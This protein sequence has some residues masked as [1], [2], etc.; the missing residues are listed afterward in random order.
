MVSVQESV[1]GQGVLELA[2]KHKTESTHL[3]GLNDYPAAAPA[4][5][6]QPLQPSAPLFQPPVTFP[7]TSL[8]KTERLPSFR[9]VLPGRDSPQQ[10]SSPFRW[11]SCCTGAPSSKHSSQL[12]KLF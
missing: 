12:H 2:R 10:N 7:G 1:E 3:S 5:Q 6:Q 8:I 9:T 11:S 4:E